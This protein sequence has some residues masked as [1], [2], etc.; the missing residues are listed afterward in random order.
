MSNQSKRAHISNSIKCHQ[1]DLQAYLSMPHDQVEM[2]GVI[3]DVQI[4]VSVEEIQS[5]VMYIPLTRNFNKPTYHHWLKAK[6]CFEF[7]IVYLHVAVFYNPQ[8]YC[9]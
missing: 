7:K 1:S 5:G 3:S 2:L 8:L 4:L 6:Y 9:N